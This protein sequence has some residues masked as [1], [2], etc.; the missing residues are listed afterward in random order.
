[1]AGPD[2]ASRVMIAVNAPVNLARIFWD[3]WLPYPWNLAAWIV[4]VGLLWY[5]VGCSVQTWRRQREA[6]LPRWRYGRLLID[7]LLITMGLLFGLM[8]AAETKEIVDWAPIS[9]RGGVGCFGALWWSELLRSMIAASMHL[10]WS[11]VLVFIFV[12]DFAHCFR[13]RNAVHA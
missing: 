5:W 12:R 8:S 9:F 6:L 3:H 4:G 7:V 1:M 11:V 10:G 13:R 2:P